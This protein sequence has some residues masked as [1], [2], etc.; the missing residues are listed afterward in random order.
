MSLK[1]VVLLLALA[2]GLGLTRTDEATAQTFTTL[3]SFSAIDPS[4]NTNSDG[5]LPEDSLILWD[6]TLYGTAN[7]GGQSFGTVFA[8]NTEDLSFTNLFSF[9]ASEGYAPVAGLTLSSNTLYGTTTFGGPGNEGVVYALTIDGGTFVPLHDFPL[10][11]G[12][13]GLYGTN[14]DGGIP[15]AG[16]VLSDNIV[17]GTAFAGGGMGWGTVFAIDTASQVFTLVHTFT[18]SSNG[19]TPYAGLVLSG[20]TLFG[21]TTGSYFPS[22][23]SG[24]GN[25]YAVNI[26]S[27]GFTNLHS[28]TNGKDGSQPFGGL[29]LSGSNLYGM[30]NAGGH[31]GYGTIFSVNTNGSGFTVLHS[32]TAPTGSLGTNSDGAQPWGGLIFSGNTLY[33][34]ASRGGTGG[35]G[36]VFSVNTD[37]SNYTTLHSFTVTASDGASP[38]PHQTNSD[39]ASP[40]GGLILSNNTLYGTAED[41]GL[42]G[43]GTIFSLSLPVVVPPQL[44]INL[45][46]SNVTLTWPTNFTGFNLQSVTNLLSPAVWTNVSPGAIIVNGRNTVTNRISGAEQFYRLSQ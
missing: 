18:G 10:F 24:F 39:G 38:S 35:N 36:T 33:G 5:A 45:S 17:Y 43:N 21:T 4:S 8:L 37:G 6:N 20:N 40:R 16:L 34:M 11:A 2:A 29:V 31:S 44:T 23:Q 27:T 9:N 42:S 41:G 28:F 14:S 26:D 30:A 46:G 32:F 7:I 1:N 25:V 3:Y 19:A 13:A 12:S 15:E 22:A